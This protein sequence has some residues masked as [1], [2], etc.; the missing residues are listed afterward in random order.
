MPRTDS[1]DIYSKSVKQQSTTAVKYSAGQTCQV[2]DR[3]DVCLDR[4]DIVFISSLVYLFLCEYI[5]C[6]CMCRPIIVH[7]PVM[8]N[9]SVDFSHQF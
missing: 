3:W 2:K 1:H 7:F 5:A 6:V 8:F 9:G 4:D